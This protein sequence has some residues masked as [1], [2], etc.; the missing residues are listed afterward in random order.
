MLDALR[1]ELAPWYLQIKFLHIIF[2]AT[3]VMS[4]S[5]AYTW[6]AQA[7]WLAWQRN[8]NDP[9]I[10]RR[11][12]WAFEQFDKG[13]SLEHIAFPL[14]LLTGL[15]MYWLAGWNLDM[16][17]LAAK[18]TIVVLIFLPMEIFDYWLSHFGGSKRQ[19]RL[20]GDSERYES[21]MSLHWWFFRVTTPL[22]IVFIPLI[23][24]LA[25]TKP[26]LAWWPF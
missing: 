18:L 7:A 16:H 22:V 9:E 24:Y 12:D 1:M 13:A 4:T 10:K 11:R 20:K 25:V 8:P 6:Y 15:L 5:V 14:L 17:W 19:Y 3:W 2:M 26:V 21:L 23:I